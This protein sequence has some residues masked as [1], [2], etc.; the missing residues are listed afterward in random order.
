[1][2]KKDQP[3]FIGAGIAVVLWMILYY[4]LVSDN[5][6]QREEFI[7][8]AK[9]TYKGITEKQGV[10]DKPEKEPTRPLS[11]ANAVLTGE[12]K[13]QA[14]LMAQLQKI[15]FAQSMPGFQHTDIK[16]GEDPKN[17]FD[18]KRKESTEAAKQKGLKFGAGYEDL[19]FRNAVIEDD[20]KVELN[21]ARLFITNQVLNAIATTQV[22]QVSAI[23]YPKP[24]LI[25]LPEDPNIEKEE[26][27]K[28]PVG[29]VR[30][31][32]APRG[33]A[34]EE[35][36]EA[37][38]PP[39]LGQIPVVVRIKM[40]EARIATLMQELQKPS[41]EGHGFLSLRG[42]EVTLR[43]KNTGLVDVE[44]AL[45]AVFSETKLKD[46]KIDLDEKKGNS[47]FVRP[48]YNNDRN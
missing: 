25:P 4:V 12:E 14:E 17:F 37:G 19:G 28:T 34:K 30:T 1:M 46:W 26:S 23:R 20:V 5:W 6:T 31:G 44:L 8:R 33:P 24:F 41:V 7:N 42:F 11:A 48:I 39:Q 21:L 16:A 43:D 32:Q 29:P 45:G 27:P 18:K 47:R 35:K 9:T 2:N 22:A 13:R 40:E 36:V 15:E 10:S 3:Y 38:P